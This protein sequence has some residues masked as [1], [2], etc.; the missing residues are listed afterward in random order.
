MIVSGSRGRNLEQRFG[1][2]TGDTGEVRLIA[3]VHYN[4]DVLNAGIDVKRLL[5][6][7]SAVS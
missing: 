5:R 6:T 3:A 1:G 2:R 4:R 7:L